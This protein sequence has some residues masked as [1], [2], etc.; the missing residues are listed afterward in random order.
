MENFKYASIAKRAISFTIDDII[1]SFLFIG[2]FYN[3][4]IALQTPESMVYFLQSNVW[5]LIALKVIYH[6]FFI[7][8]NG[9]TVGKYL[10][11][12]KAV[13]ENSGEVIG[14]YRAFIRAVVRALGEMLFYITFIFAFASPKK[15][16]LHD[17]I[18]NCVVIDVKK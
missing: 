7:G 15:Q 4:I 12:I 5:Y 16:T 18:V 8:L 13:D 10:M 6:T 11:K 9:M 17:K 2:I 1:T 3:S 14:Y